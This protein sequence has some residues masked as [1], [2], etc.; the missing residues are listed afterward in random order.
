M[1]EVFN[2]QFP[3]VSLSGHIQRVFPERKNVQNNEI[4]VEG[5]KL[6]TKNTLRRKRS[7]PKWQKARFMD[8]DPIRR[9]SSLG[10]SKLATK[11]TPSSSA[12]GLVEFFRWDRNGNELKNRSCLE[13]VPKK[14][15]TPKWTNQRSKSQKQKHFASK[16]LRAENFFIFV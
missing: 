16:N 3:R 7:K 10:A 9:C 14:I 5:L 2:Q 6:K 13:Y 1:D 4:C 11:E 8:L 15:H 12:W